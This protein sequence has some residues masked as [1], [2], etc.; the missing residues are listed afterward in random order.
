MNAGHLYLCMAKATV[1][2][3]VLMSPIAWFAGMR[4]EAIVAGLFALANA[5]IF[6]VL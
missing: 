1:G 5:I 3:Y 4:R 2:L 6:K